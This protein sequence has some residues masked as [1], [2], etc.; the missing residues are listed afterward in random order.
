MAA[1]RI[2]SIAPCRPRRLLLPQRTNVSDQRLDL[3][4]TQLVRESGIA[5]PFFPFLMVSVIS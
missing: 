4:V 1:S 2:V 5:V 3:V